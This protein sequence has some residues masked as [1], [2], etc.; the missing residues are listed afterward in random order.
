M[1]LTSLSIHFF[2]SLVILR[3]L[4]LLAPGWL[5]CDFTVIKSILN[6]FII[7]AS[8]S[9]FPLILPPP[10]QKS[11]GTNPQE[12]RER[13]TVLQTE[14]ENYVHSSGEKVRWAKKGQ[15]ACFYPLPQWLPQAARAPPRRG[16]LRGAR[17]DRNILGAEALGGGVTRRQEDFCQY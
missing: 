9:V 14:F 6:C 15:W 13:A 7:P 11:R 2:F 4:P 16:A 3:G 8:S 17:P 12:V 10:S 5:L 1:T